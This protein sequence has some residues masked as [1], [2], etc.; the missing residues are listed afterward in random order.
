MDYGVRSVIT[1]TAFV[2]IGPFFYGRNDS[3]ASEL[4]HQLYLDAFQGTPKSLRM[5]LLSP[6]TV[7]GVRSKWSVFLTFCKWSEPDATYCLGTELEAAAHWGRAKSQLLG[8]SN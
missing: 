1:H 3:S 6:Q 5:A 8:T 7:G 4:L 2:H